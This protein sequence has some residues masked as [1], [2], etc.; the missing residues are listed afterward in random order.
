MLAGLAEH[1]G[2]ATAYSPRPFDVAMAGRSRG[3]LREQLGNEQ[4]GELHTQGQRSSFEEIPKRSF[5]G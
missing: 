1:L 5:S 2:S 3:R 4:Y